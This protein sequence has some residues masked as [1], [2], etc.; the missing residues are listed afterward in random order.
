MKSLHPNV[1]VI[2]AGPSGLMAAIAAASRGAKAVVLEQMDRAGLKLLAT[3]GGRCNLT[4][5]AS[6]SDVMAAFGRQ[7]RFMSN[8]L[9]AMDGEG[10]RR[11]FAEHGVPTVCPDGFEVYP[12]SLKAADVLN[13]LLRACK[14][15]GVEV[16]CSQIV[17]NL[18]LKSS[19]SSDEA[20]R[21]ALFVRGVRANG[22]EVPGGKAI[23]CCGGRSYPSLGATGGG[24]ALA[25]QAGHT[26]V[27]PTPAGVGLICRDEAL[28]ECAGVSV[29]DVRVWIDLPKFAKTGRRGDLLF[30]HRGLSGP[31][32]LDISGDVAELLAS[33]P[34]S[35]HRTQRGADQKAPLSSIS[36]SSAP[37][38]GSAV[39]PL[40][41]DL[42]PDESKAHWSAQLD[43]WGHNIGARQV[44]YLL[45][46]RLTQAVG[47]LVCQLSN[48]S[49]ITP[50][51]HVDRSRRDALV[52]NIKSLP[53]AVTGTEGFDRA[54]VTRGGVVLKEVDPRTLQSR[55]AAGLFFAGELLD[56]DG[57]CGGYNLTWAFSSGHLAGLSAA[58][59]P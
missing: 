17:D 33:P 38:A 39:V 6:N 28:R 15:L 41:I 46:P 35:T 13:A 2:G 1:L 52:A 8:A 42:T 20:C 51:A 27:P 55:L 44:R 54:I 4:N 25:A 43:E 53:A 58:E 45:A 24:Y 9:T 37:S 21:S 59:K 7:G 10:I 5:T 16:R 30:T 14:G 31:A 11:F 49:P 3:G 23:L 19:K 26:L 12:E 47:E 29:K 50:M 22:K 56:L 57:P 32:V 34:R 18:L 48:I 40:R 36:S